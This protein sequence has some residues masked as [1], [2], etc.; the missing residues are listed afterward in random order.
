IE[1]QD[2]AAEPDEIETDADLEDYDED[3]YDPFANVICVSVTGDDNTG[4]GTVSAPFATIGKAI[5]VAVDGKEIYVSEGVYGETLVINKDNI[6][7]LGGFS[8]TF[9]RDEDYYNDPAKSGASEENITRIISAHE[10]VVTF[11][12]TLENILF[13]GFTVGSFRDTGKA[14]GAVTVKSGNPVISYCTLIG[15]NPVGELVGLN[16]SLSAGLVIGGG[17][18]VIN[19]NNITAGEAV[20]NF[21]TIGS[22]TA[23]SI[24]I[25]IGEISSIGAESSVSAE[26][27]NN[28]IVAGHSKDEG[29]DGGNVGIGV[30][31]NN[32]D[33]KIHG[34]IISAGENKYKAR[35]YGVLLSKNTGIVLYNNIIHG[36][37]S[38]DL[39]AGIYFYDATSEKVY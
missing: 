29:T 3:T 34:N 32:G 38:T 37:K 12:G 27:Y 31:R 4:D 9:E 18:P 19:N 30:Y 39:T 16:G 36:G 8:A 15:G 11:D 28:T 23:A 33:V 35:S 13:E 5:E 24:G 7:I 2:D 22:P 17:S 14:A 25:V 21:T 6:K 26:I 20:D 10:S 1:E